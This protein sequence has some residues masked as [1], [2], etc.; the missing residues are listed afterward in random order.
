MA[1]SFSAEGSTFN[2]A[3]GPAVLPAEVLAR[4]RDELPGLQD[5]G[6]TVWEMPF[7]C[8][9][10]R[11]IQAR[12]EAALR[13]LLD[14]PPHYRVLFMHGGASLQF[15]LLPLNLGCGGAAADYVE[16]GHWSRKAIAEARRYGPVNVAASAVSSG[17]SRLPRQDEWHCDARAAYCHVTANETAD[18]LEYHW[19]PDTGAVPLVADMSSNLL[20]RPL[21]VTRYG[22]IYAGAQKNIGPAGLT[23][24]IVREDLLDRPACA[25]TPSVLDYRV[26]AAHGSRFN[27]PLT[28][29]I[30]LAGLV[31]DW[32]EAGGGLAAMAAANARKSSRIY[33]AIDASAG[34]YRCA[35]APADRSRMNICFALPDA[36]ATAAFLALAGERRLLH[37]KG[38]GA[39]GGIRASLYNAMPE[40]GAA[41]LGEF[42]TEFA[43][44]YDAR[45]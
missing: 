23:L 8:A 33:T 14:I 13:R 10:F 6:M 44:A 16:S 24:V 3:A 11:D 25:A 1:A 29:A 30:Y 5:G 40:A 43:A 18:G 4:L 7:D 2:F 32:L 19:T 9:A 45:R 42:M 34:F 20:S 38:H 37:L 36:S 31:F 27:T 39:V 26:Q 21:D 22:L 35:A 28:Y 41:A 12:A 15:S 17:F